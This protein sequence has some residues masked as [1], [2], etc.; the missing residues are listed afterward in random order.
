MKH[1]SAKEALIGRIRS[2][3]QKFNEDHPEL[4]QNSIPDAAAAEWILENA[5][6]F[7]C[8][9]PE[10]EEVYY[11]R[12]WAFRKHL[13]ETPEGTV[14][15][16]FLPDV[17]WSGKYNTIVCPVSHHV[18]EAR[19]LKNRT[20][21]KDDIRHFLRPENAELTLAY[22]NPLIADVCAYCLSEPDLPFA[23]EC[24][25]ELL[26]LYGE[27]EAR[28]LT[29][30]GLFWSDDDRDGMEYSISG[31]GLR[32]TLN[33][34]MYGAAAGLA[35]LCTLLGETEKAALYLERAALLKTKIREL[36]WDKTDGFFK[37]VPMASRDSEVDSERTS[38]AAKVLEEVGFVPFAYPGLTDQAQTEAYRYLMDP[39]HFN[40]PR[41][42]TSADPSHPMFM[43]N[44]VHHECLWDGPVWP[45]S[46]SQTLTGLYTALRNQTDAIAPAD[47]MALLRTYAASHV[48]YEN[49]HR[50]R[51][52]DENQ[53]PFT[54]QWIARD[55][56]HHDHA[57]GNIFPKERGANY[58]HSTFCDLV[59]SGACGISIENG[60]LSVQPLCKGTWKH[61]AVYGLTVRGAS[62]DIIYT[63][64]EIT[65]EN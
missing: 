18:H 14:I 63:D 15:T 20:I 50:I 4:Y 13:K 35:G 54:G 28:H 9:D 59:L 42:I 7:E 3:V 41:G 2:Y 31:P 8:D 40:A 12:F 52:I 60:T 49:G 61:F 34:Y 57:Y 22:S 62:K 38:P 6:L 43:K 29:A 24:L 37:T 39:L 64:G 51:W 56:I 65:I 55:L 26:R 44:P 21:V 27:W 17:S 33:A 5:P 11:F 19:W 45:Y 32:P 1:D 48:L 23:K 36:L 46:T 53:D 16:E 25:P 10:I 30:S 47:Y 58:N